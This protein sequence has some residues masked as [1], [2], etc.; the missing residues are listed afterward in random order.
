MVGIAGPRFIKVHTGKFF[1][2]WKLMKNTDIHLRN[3]LTHTLLF[4]HFLENLNFEFKNILEYIRTLFSGN[5][6]LFS[7]T[8]DSEL[9]KYGSLSWKLQ[10][11]KVANLSFLNTSIRKNKI[12]IWQIFHFYEIWFWIIFKRKSVCILIFIKKNI[13]QFLSSLSVKL[14]RQYA[15]NSWQS[16]R[17]CAR[18]WVSIREAGRPW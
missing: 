15:D 17:I 5:T 9:L 3:L 7:E 14:Y 13:L 10:K 6:W 4:W 2:D 1:K 18:I 16:H 8:S 12:A 11:T